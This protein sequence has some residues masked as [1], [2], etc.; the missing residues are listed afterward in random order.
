VVANKNN[1]IFISDIHLPYEHPRALQ[2]CK[3]LKKDFEIPDSNV[4]S[5]GDVLDLYGFS[6]WPKSPDAKHTINQ[7][8]DIARDKIVK[9]GAA[10][11]EMKICESNHDQ[12]IMRKALG[13]DLPSQVIRSME[14]IFSL[15]KGWEIKPEFI[16]MANKWEGI[17]CHGEEFADA[18]AAAMHYGI[19]CIQGHRHEKA[20][21]QWMR[22]RHQTLWG[23]A[24]SCL[25]DSESFAF[26]YGDKNKRKPLIGVGLVLNGIPHF[27]PLE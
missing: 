24:V 21:V 1:F 17:I 14:E 13:A 11:P 23:M 8:L 12:R 25:V 27:I 16:I 6:R 2:F 26:A 20:G 15:P 5:V 22:T 7:E 3:S 18:L 9:W 19:N 10:F 4:Y